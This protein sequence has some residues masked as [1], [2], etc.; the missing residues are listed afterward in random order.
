MSQIFSLAA[1]SGD[2][3]YLPTTAWQGPLTKSSH[4]TSHQTREASI[5]ICILPKE[6]EKKKKKLKVVK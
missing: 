1:S 5:S 3:T 4:I 2:S 6:G